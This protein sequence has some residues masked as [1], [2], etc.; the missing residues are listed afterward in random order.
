MRNYP[1]E[2]PNLAGRAHRVVAEII[3]TCGAMVGCI[4]AD[5][6]NGGTR[7]PTHDGE[8]IGYRRVLYARQLG[9]GDDHLVPER[10]PQIV[11]IP[12]CGF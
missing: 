10:A 7:V 12:T 4:A 3:I 11:V 2:L 8:L 9:G 6:A 5:G 1:D